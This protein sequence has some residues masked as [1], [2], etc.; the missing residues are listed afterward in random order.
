MEEGI[1]YATVFTDYAHNDEVNLKIS[2]SRA[3]KDFSH[4]RYFISY[5]EDGKMK[6]HYPQLGDSSAQ[7]PDKGLS[8]YEIEWAGDSSFVNEEGVTCYY[9]D[10]TIDKLNSYDSVYLWLDMK[11]AFKP[12]TI[13]FT[14][15]CSVTLVVEGI[16]VIQKGSDIKSYTFTTTESKQSI[17]FTCRDL[18]EDTQTKGWFYRT[19][20]SKTSPIFSEGETAK[21]EALD[22]DVNV[23]IYLSTVN[24][25]T[26]VLDA[27]SG[28]RVYDNFSERVLSNGT[29]HTT[30]DIN[31]TKIDITINRNIFIFGN[32]FPIFRP[33]GLGPITPGTII[34]GPIIPNQFENIHDRFDYVWQPYLNGS[35]ISGKEEKTGLNLVSGYRFQKNNLST[36]EGYSYKL[37]IKTYKNYIT[38][39]LMITLLSI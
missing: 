18:P 31:N 30:P 26:W 35:T 5:Y 8:Y 22:S 25:A 7:F 11:E 23:S 32:N 3:I 21:V 2:S 29:Y 4:Y 16:K 34:P 19:S 24:V 37:T 38:K 1:S 39:T 27:S 20:A 10:K 33:F 12:H 15:H 36:T 9:F 28:A 6:L 14:L 17:T 13:T